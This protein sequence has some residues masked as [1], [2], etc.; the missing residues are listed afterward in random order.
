MITIHLGLWLVP[1]LVLV[2]GGIL[3]MFLAQAPVDSHCVH[4]GT[5]LGPLFRGLCDKCLEKLA[6]H[7]PARQPE[8]EPAHHDGEFM[9]LL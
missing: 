7:Q 5:P 3:F 8:Y 1:L 9:K 2:L 4:C 6:P